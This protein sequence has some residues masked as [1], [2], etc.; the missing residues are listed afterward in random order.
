MNH[1]IFTHE[2]VPHS[3][4]VWLSIP[5]PRKF[6]HELAKNSLLTKIL[7]PEKYLLYSIEVTI[8]I[9]NAPPIQLLAGHSG[10]GG[11]AS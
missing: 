8:P 6:F 3:T 2:K 10:G 7:A 11:S 9:P 5:R 4:R 1:E